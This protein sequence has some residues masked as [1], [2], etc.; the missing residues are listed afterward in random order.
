MSLIAAPARLSSLWVT[1]G[2]ALPGPK[3]SNRMISRSVRRNS[4]L[5]LGHR[6]FDLEALDT[7]VFD[8]EAV[9]HVDARLARQSNKKY[10]QC[11]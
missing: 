5:G 9:V 7:G 10:F 6:L 2:V 4:R 11:G 3:T 1:F 8:C